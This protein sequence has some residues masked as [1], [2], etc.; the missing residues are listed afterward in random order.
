MP[1]RR[2]ALLAAG[3]A[4]I[5]AAATTTFA[6]PGGGN[7][8]VYFK[9]RKGDGSIVSKAGE[10]KESPA[11]ISV[12]AGG[13][14]VVA[15]PATDIVRVE[16]SALPGLDNADK[17]SMLSFDNKA[18]S[19]TKKDASDAKAAFAAMVK[20]APSDEKTRRS[21]DYRD[22][23]WSARAAD[24]APAADYAKEAG[25]AADKLR[26]VALATTKSWETYPAAKLAARLYAD[27]GKTT[28]AS[29]VL[30]SVAKLKDLP[31]DLKADAKVTE[32]AITFRG[33][34]KLAAETLLSDILK[35]KDFPA[36]GPSRD[37]L[38]VYQVAVKANAPKEGKP[39]ELVNA[40]EAVIGK[41]AD[42][43]TRAAARNALGDFYYGAGRFRDAMWEYLW[44]ETVFNQDREEVI[45]AVGR[46][47]DVLEKL[48]D[49]DR[50]DAY[51]LKLIEVRSG[52]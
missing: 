29:G 40:V 28:E 24:F 9:D 38:S 37:I 23:V 10:L 5:A 14:L 52:N 1:F 34:G 21:L 31:A 41:T 2:P 45:Y 6:Q 20:K 33:S 7:D 35:D 44:V 51:R 17:Q 4:L 12:F 47:V 8:R 32:L 30:S 11:G 36:T 25:A 13:K 27:I 19:Y 39:T 48:N 43:G 46:L 16:Y 42:P 3:F 15:V 49:K 18:A 22:A 26:A 50:A